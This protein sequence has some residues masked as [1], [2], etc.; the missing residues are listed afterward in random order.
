MPV[1]QT[2]YLLVRVADG[3]DREVV[4]RE[5]AARLSYVDVLTTAEF[6]RKQAFYWMFETGAG[7]SVLLAA[8]LGL[9]VGVV[10]V[11][12]T[13]YASTM[14]HLREYGTLKAMGATNGY[15]YGVIIRQAVISLVVAASSQKTTTA[16]F[17][18]GWLLGALFVVTLVMCIAASMVS[19]NKVTRLDPAMI[20]KG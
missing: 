13:I 5:I 19:I 9:V 20:F 17:L 3:V 10:V 2:V 15:L 4:R 7:V 14:D 18:P 6:G 12:Q 8:L 16:I 1:D 11:A